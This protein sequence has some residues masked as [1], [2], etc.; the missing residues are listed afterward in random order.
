MMSIALVHETQKEVR[1][2]LIVGSELAA[3]YFRLLR[4]MPNLKKAGE[5]VPVFAKVAEAIEKAVDSEKGQSAKRLL[6][7][8]S[9]TNAVIYTQ[10]EAGIQGNLEPAGNASVN[11]PTELSY[12]KLSPIIDALTYTGQGRYEIISNAANNEKLSD[13]RL[14]MPLINALDDGYSEIPPLVYRILQGFGE[15]LIPVLQKK[16][17]LSGGKSA[18]RLFELLAGFLGTAGKALCLDAL[19]NGSTDIKVS[20]ISV[21]SFDP[22]C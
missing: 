17:D 4:I 6:E 18:A 1:R 21:L 10:G 19:E 14:I 8:A 16:L 15:E 9:I 7:L 20:A 13:L 3:S 12:R 11:F 5:R 22:E 2:L